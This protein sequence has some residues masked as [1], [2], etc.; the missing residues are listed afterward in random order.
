M[1]EESTQPRNRGIG[2]DPIRIRSKHR[3]RVLGRLT[4]GGATVSEL[5]ND[6]GLR[7]PHASAELK[8][9]R[10]DGLVSS[11]QSEGSRG[12][13]MHLTQ[14]GWEAIRSDELSRAIEASP[15]PADSGMCC[16]LSRA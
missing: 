9:L 11:D 6:V 12:A 5:A 10:N 3:R 7:V 8:R 16:L 1:P 15:I 14:S 13:S 4:E 2:P